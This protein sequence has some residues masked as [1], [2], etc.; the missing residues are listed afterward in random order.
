[1]PTREN[2]PDELR[3]SKI[4]TAY[5][6]SKE[7]RSDSLNWDDL[8]ALRDIWPHKLLVKGLLHPDDAL[9]S[10]E[11]GA[12]G[13]IVSNH[14]GRNCDAA[15]S[16]IEVLP[17][18]VKAVGDRTTVIFDSGVR[19]G[20]DVVKAL[21]LGADAVMVGRSTLYGVA[22]GGEAGAAR[23]LEIYREEIHRNI[24]LLGCSTIAELGPQCLQFVDAQLRP[25][26]LSRPAL[27][28]VDAKT[29]GG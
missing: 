27:R 11:Y 18:I 4:T 21:A 20:S 22:A 23:A 10:L 12:D 3:S 13:I 24:A 16:P 5:G 17:D 9:K 26:S 15:P 6:G 25:P 7:T 1:M 19:R 2:F 29:A 8:K 28:A 14:G